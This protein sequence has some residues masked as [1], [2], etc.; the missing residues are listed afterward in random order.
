LSASESKF[1]EPFF[2]PLLSISSIS[3]PTPRTESAV[4]SSTLP[5]KRDVPKSLMGNRAAI[6]PS[7]GGLHCH[8]N[9]LLRAVLSPLRAFTA[10]QDFHGL[11]LTEYLRGTHHGSKSIPESGRRRRSGDTWAGTANHGQGHLAPSPDPDCMLF[12]QLS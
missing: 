12:D 5:L 6:V 8:E 9:W 4:S 3:S 10:A 11:R 1:Y 7:A 2:V